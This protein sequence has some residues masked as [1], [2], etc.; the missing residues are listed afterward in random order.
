M[1]LK[2]AAL[3]LALI[4]L[5]PAAA[6]A[7]SPLAQVPARPPLVVYLN[8]L[9]ST[10]ARAQELLKGVDATLHAKAKPL[11]KDVRAPDLGGRKITGLAKNGAVFLALMEV[12][13]AGAG[14]KPVLVVEVE[15]YATF[16]DGL[17]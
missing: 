10:R 4:A 6:P 3:G 9:G 8:G 12:P 13:R 14:L 1:P 16:R 15:K 17:L 7:A 2:R 11:L 5:P